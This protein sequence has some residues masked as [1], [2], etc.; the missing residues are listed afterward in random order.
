MEWSV[1]GGKV[2]NRKSVG[3]AELKRGV[4]GGMECEGEEVWK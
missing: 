4:E 3:W 2:W 1:R